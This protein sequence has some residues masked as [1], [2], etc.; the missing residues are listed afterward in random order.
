MRGFTLIELMIVISIM[1]LLG[2]FTIANYRSFGEDKDLENAALDVVSLIRTAQTNATTNLKCVNDGGIWQIEYI[3][4]S[5]EIKLN[6]KEPLADFIKKKT[7]QLKTNIQV[8]SV[9]GSPPIACTGLTINFKPI[10]GQI[11]LGGDEACDSLTATLKNTT[12]PGTKN[13]IIEKGGKIYV[14]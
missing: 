7:L 3:T 4:G 8:D 6:C 1:A 11:E 14:N 2:A 5:P 9:I 13:V 12:R 10:N